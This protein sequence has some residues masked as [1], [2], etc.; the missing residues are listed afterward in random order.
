MAI[1]LPIAE[2]ARPGGRVEVLGIHYK[3]IRARARDGVERSW[4]AF[5]GRAVAASPS[6]SGRTVLVLVVIG[7]VFAWLYLRRS[8]RR[9]SVASLLPPGAPLPVPD[10]IPDVDLPSDPA[11]ALD[12][13]AR[14][15][16]DSVRE[17]G[18]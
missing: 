6:G 7:M 4:T 14:R 10:P 9:G 8:G 15:H 2:D 18:P 12:E 3:R 17:V 11:A 1:Y 13:L 16:D 5:V